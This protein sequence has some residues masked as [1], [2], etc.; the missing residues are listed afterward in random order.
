MQVTFRNEQGTPMESNGGT[1]GMS[2]CKEPEAER[3]GGLRD[4]EKACV[5][6][7]ELDRLRG[8]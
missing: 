2:R 5:A 4:G 3:V 7:A 8:I 6:V 1:V